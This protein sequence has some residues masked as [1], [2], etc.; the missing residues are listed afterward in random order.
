M[1]SDYRLPEIT[2]LLKT[3]WSETLPDGFEGRLQALSQYRQAL[4]EATDEA[5][6]ARLSQAY[7]KLKESLLQDTIHDRTH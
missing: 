3:A 5:E 7:D 2:Q 1:H 6:R 4:Q